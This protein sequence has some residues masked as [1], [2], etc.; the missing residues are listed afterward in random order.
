MDPNWRLDSSPPPP[1]TRPSPPPP[2][3]PPCS[4]PPPP[5]TS[6]IRGFENP[7]IAMEVEGEFQEWSGA[8]GD[9]V[10]PASPSYH[11]IRRAAPISPPARRG[12]GAISPPGRGGATSPPGRGARAISPPLRNA[13]QAPRDTGEVFNNNN[14]NNSNNNNNQVMSLDNKKLYKKEYSFMCISRLFLTAL[15]RITYR[16][17]QLC[18]IATLKR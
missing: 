13:P 5:P 11:G 9:H 4:P 14:N 2:S 18:F 16:R 8:A 1:P 6:T 3:P 15:S 10:S 12:A 17:N 7:G